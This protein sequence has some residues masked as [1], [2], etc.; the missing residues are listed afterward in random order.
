MVWV[1]Y[2]SLYC[3]SGILSN[4]HME[5]WRHFVLACRLLCKPTLTSDDI[6]LADALL[7]Q[8]CRRFV[9]TYGSDAATPNMHMHTHLAE[10]VRDFGTISSFWLFSF[11]RF[12]GI[13]GGQPTNNR[14]IELQIMKRFVQDNF[15]IQVLSLIPYNCSDV[16]HHFRPVVADHAYSFY[17]TRHLDTHSLVSLYSHS[18]KSVQYSPALKYTLAVFQQHQIDVLHQTYLLLYPDI[19]RDL[20]ASSLPSTYR[21]MLSITINRQVIRAGQYVSAKSVFGFHHERETDAPAHTVFSNPDIRPA[22][23]DHFAVHSL[24]VNSTVVNH[25]FAI[26][27]WP[28]CHPLRNTIGKP[29]EIWS[30][31]NHSY[32]YNN[33]ILPVENISSFLLC[34]ETIIDGQNVL[35]TVPL[36]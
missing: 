3:L 2:Y 18:A 28:M 7:L 6:S 33:L 9:N 10:C 29:V 21:R 4:E 22:K 23:I 17:S 20:A 16:D 30:S 15:H 19:H 24:Q 34:T 13:L 31:V 26:V 1:L 32:S 11:E 12:N 36:L 8:F 25:T 14:S 35:V 5:L 27:Q